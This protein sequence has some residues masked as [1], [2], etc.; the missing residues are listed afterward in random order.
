M[1]HHNQ[2]VNFLNLDFEAINT[3]IL[4]YETQEKEGEAIA[5]I[6][7]EGDNATVGGPVDKEHVKEVITAP[8]KKTFDIIFLGGVVWTLAASY[9]EA[10]ISRL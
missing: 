9:F 1:K 10:F 5:A 4:A 7:V 8:W 3:K 2:V 6:V